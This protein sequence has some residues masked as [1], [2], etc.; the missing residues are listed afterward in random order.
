V[1]PAAAEGKKG[2]V[3]DTP[4]PGREDPA[5]LKL[6]HMGETPNPGREDPALFF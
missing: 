6:A 3:G 2:V 5:P 4:N 1:P